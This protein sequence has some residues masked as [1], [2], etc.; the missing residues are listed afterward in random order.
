MRPLGFDGSRK[1]SDLFG[2]AKLSAAARV[3]L[4]IVCDMIGPIWAPGICL[5][6]RMKL[7]G[8]EERAIILRFG[9]V[10]QDPSH[11]METGVRA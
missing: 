4:P 9:Q 5:D 2:E 1:L 11:N 10:R 8:L 3:R 7:T 6:Q